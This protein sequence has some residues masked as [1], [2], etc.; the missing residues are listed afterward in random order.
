MKRVTFLVLVATCGLAACSNDDEIDDPA[1]E[2]PSHFDAVYSVSMSSMP[3]TTG[4]FSDENALGNMENGML[5]EASGLAVSAQDDNLLWSHNDSGDMNRLF[6]FDKQGNH[7][8]IFRILG[9]GNRDWE[10]MACGAGPEQDQHYLYVADIGDNHRRWSEVYVYRFPEPNVDSADPEAQWVD[11]QSEVVERFPVK[12]PD[13]ARDAETLLLDPWSLDLYVVSKSDFPA[14]IYRL[15]YPY[16]HQEERTFELYGTIPVT[17]LTGGDI[18]PDGK[19]IVMKTKERIWLWTRDEGESLRDALMR[20]PIRV[21]YLPEPQ[22]EAI[23]FDA[24]GLN[25]YTLSEK[26]S[27]S[28]APII[29]RYDRL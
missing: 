6:L 13:G 12:Y 19:A 23:A 4:V 9:A 11:V 26:G 14:R 25:F 22:G 2:Q 28:L 15:A 18:S 24:E 1:L 27:S 8:G 21:P 5:D 20:E 16:E 10:D 17:M 7:K 29:Y 3:I